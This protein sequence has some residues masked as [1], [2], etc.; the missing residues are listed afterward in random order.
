MVQ[1]LEGH[2]HHVLDVAWQSDG[3]LIASAGSDRK[4][5]LWDL[6]T[7]EQLT[8]LNRG[9]GKIN[10]VWLE[11]DKP[12]N[13]LRFVGDT[14]YILTSSGNQPVQ[15]WDLTKEMRPGNYAKPYFRGRVLR[16]FGDGEEFAYGIDASSDGGIVVAGGRSGVARLFNGKDGELVRELAPPEELEPPES[17]A[18]GGRKPAGTD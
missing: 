7:G 1:E 18:S 4:V 11:H 5:R 12:V 14:T 3:K 13:R 16:S 17:Q 9:G 6:A 8:R 2:T 15:L 10:T